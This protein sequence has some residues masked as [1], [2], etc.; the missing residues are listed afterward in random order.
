MGV[1]ISDL[2]AAS[3]VA[4]ANE[5]EINESGTSKKVTAAQIKSYATNATSVTAAGALMDSELTDVAAVKGINQALTTSSSPTFGGMTTTGDISFG[6]NNKAIFGAGDLQIYHD[7]SHSYITD[8]GTGNLR[9]RGTDITLQDASGNGYISMVDGGAGGTVYLKHLGSNVLTTTSTGIDVTGT[10]TADGLTVDGDVLLTTNTATNPVVIART[11]NTSESLQISIDDGNAIFKSEQD[12]TGRYGGF[13]F[14]GRHSGTD[15]NRLLIDHTTGDIS[16]YED[17]GTTAKFFWDASA[18]SLGIGTSSPQDALHIAKASAVLRLEDTDTSHISTIQ[19]GGSGL[20]ISAD[21]ANTVASSYMGFSVDGSERM[22]IDSSGNVQF[23]KNS[24]TVVGSIGSA[25]IA[26]GTNLIID[27]PNAVYFGTNI[28]PE[29]DNTY[30]VGSASYRFDDIYAT[31]GTIQTSDINEKQDIELLSEAEQ[32]VA[33]AAKG[34]MR[35]FRWESAVAEKGEAARTHFGIIA[36]DLQAAFEAEGL[37]AGKY[38]MFISSTWTDEE[39]GEERTRLG[40]RYSE[41]LAFII[42][43]I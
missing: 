39:T 10:V 38:A 5:F 1:K 24:S 19:S 8:S 17:T 12:E 13:K 16:F 20:I 18:E 31:N 30:D 34:L 11:G 32:R 4:D 35:K 37:D 22:R 28:R 25:T 7:G 23:R 27:A 14:V 3:N 29:T 40:V 43:S 42:A 9:I 15:R 33:V 2:T 26:G 41:L 6:D 36:Q 21:A